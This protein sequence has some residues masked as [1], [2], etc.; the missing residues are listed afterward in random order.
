MKQQEIL[1]NVIKSFVTGTISRMQIKEIHK[2]LMQ[3]WKHPCSEEKAG[4]MTSKDQIQSVYKLKLH[5]FNPLGP[6]KME[7]SSWGDAHPLSNLSEFGQSSCNTALTKELL[8]LMKSLFTSS[9]FLFRTWVHDISAIRNTLGRF[10]SPLTLFLSPHI[11]WPTAEIPV[12]SKTVSSTLKAQFLTAG[13]IFKL[14]KHR[15]FLCTAPKCCSDRDIINEPTAGDFSAGIFL[16]TFF[17]ICCAI[18]ITSPHM[19][20]P[21]WH[22]SCSHKHSSRNLNEASL[23]DKAPGFAGKHLIKCNCSI[24]VTLI[25]QKW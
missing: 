3:V 22:C 16:L 1:Q 9:Y 14:F 20:K 5:I 23:A 10:P 17:L 24:S 13:E 2:Q 25:W 21:S 6:Q 8:S 15:N 11:H 12:A 18:V 7:S 4:E 19:Q